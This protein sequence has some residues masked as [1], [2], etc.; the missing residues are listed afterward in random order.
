MVHF[1]LTSQDINNTANALMLKEALGLV[2][3]PN[4]YELLD[5]VRKYANSYADIPML[6]RTHGQPASPTTVGKEFAVFA[7]RLE[8]QLERLQMIPIYGK[9][10][11]ATGNYHTHMVAYPKVNWPAKMQSFFQVLNIDLNPVTTQIEPYDSL[12]EVF[13]GMR[14]INTILFDLSQDMWRY[15]SDNYFKLKTMK[16]EI[17]SSTMPHKVNPID[18]ENAEGNLGLANAVFT[19]LAAKLPVSRLQRDL[20]DS[21]VLRNMGVPFAHSIIAYAALLRG[22]T[23]VDLNE[24]AIKE[25]LENN[26]EVLA[27]A[28]QTIMRKC[29]IENPYEKLKELTR[30]KHVTLE[31]IRA[32][33]ETLDLPK[34]DK[35]LLLKLTPETYT[36]LAAT[37]ARS[38]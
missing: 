1:G 15:I 12:A 32:F 18:F 23:K 30:G 31:E 11:G 7:K 10:S 14:R 9:F 22:M 13:D 8:H 24:K 4:L 2:I 27:E 19:H 20:T 16:G 17:G 5:F 28:V 35:Q 33:V 3:I 21:T 38:A 34:E 36:G 6:S 37:L 25:D 29:G 26:P